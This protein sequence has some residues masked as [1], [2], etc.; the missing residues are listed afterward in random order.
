METIN[1][2]FDLL[3]SSQHMNYIGEPIS[4]LNHAL[5]CAK[6]A[7]DAGYDNEVIIACL[8][9]D[10][11]HISSNNKYMHS[12]TL[13]MKNESTKSLG[14]VNHEK[15]GANFLRELGF[16]DRLCSFV[17][18][19]INTKRYLTSI[20]PE[21]FNKLS[22]ASIKTLSLQGGP[23]NSTEAKAYEQIHE[24]FIHLK[25][26]EWDDKAKQKNM[27]VY[28]LESY[29]ELALKCLNNICNKNTIIKK[30]NK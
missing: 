14:I 10:I 30:I 27:K 9:H 23:M 7:Q 16:S 8:F 11:G 4:Q 18:N 20:K 25:I 21:Y 22:P 26:R 13:N 28:P 5:Q 29:K 12:N 15:V 2:L 3:K 6:F 1:Y 24:L 17:E 19:H